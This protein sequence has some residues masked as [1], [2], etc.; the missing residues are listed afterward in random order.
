MKNYLDDTKWLDSLKK[1]QFHWE[2]TVWKPKL[3]THKNLLPRTEI[4]WLKLGSAPSKLFELKDAFQKQFL[5]VSSIDFE[6]CLL[7][8]E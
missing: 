8:G 7:D 3:R 6:A 2:K 5:E 4:R 1:D